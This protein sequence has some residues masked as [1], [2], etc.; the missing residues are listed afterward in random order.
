MPLTP[1]ISSFLTIGSVYFLALVSP[2]PDFTLTLRN[3]LVYSRK[4][5]LIGVLGTTTGIA[6]HLSYTLLGLSFLMTKFPW[7]L[8]GIRCLGASYLAYIGYKTIRNASHVLIDPKLGHSKHAKKDLTPFEAY[9][10]SFLTNALN[11]LVILFFVGILSG[12]V[13][14]TTP[15]SIQALY[16][17]FI[18]LICA[19][20]LSFVAVCFSH[21]H[22]R[23]QFNKLGF[24][25]ERFTGGVL[26]AFGIKLGLSSIL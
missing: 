25:I 1:Y 18:C 16:A 12:H 15:I 5:T 24:W 20:W 14:S 26:I 7:I 2:G 21:K 9:R 22:I 13:T 11:P 8:T 3:S 17:I 4:T 6:M 10:T 19:L 23:A